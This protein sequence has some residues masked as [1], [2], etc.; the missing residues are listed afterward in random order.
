MDQFRD[1][2]GGW[3]WVA[4][5]ACFVGNVLNG[6]L[7]YSV[8]IFHVALLEEFQED[9]ATTAIV[10]SVYAGLYSLFGPFVS[11]VVNTTSC[12]TALMIGAVL[13]VLG[14]SSCF[15]ANSLSTVLFTY[16]IIAGL[17]S[18]FCATPILIM[19]GYSFKKYRGIANGVV[20]C[21]CG[22]GMLG[23]GPLSQYFIDTYGL[24][25]GFLMMGAVACHLIVCAALIRPSGAEGWHKKMRQ[26]SEDASKKCV[27]VRS[28]LDPSLY[29]NHAFLL[30]LIAGFGWN[31]AYAIVLLHLPNFSVVLGSSKAEA[32]MLLFVIGVGSSVS[33]VFG[34]LVTSN[35]AGIDPILLKLGVL[36]ITGVLTL[37]FP[38]YSHIYW[39]QVI[40]ACLFGIY[41]GGLIAFTVPIL[42]EIVGL[43]KLSAAVGAL[44]FMYG[45]GWFVGPTVAGLIIDHTGSYDIVFYV[46]GAIFTLAS[47]LTLLSTI[48]RPKDV[49]V[50]E[51]DRFVASVLF[52]D[53]NF[54]TG[55]MLLTGSTNVMLDFRASTMNMSHSSKSLGPYSSY[56]S[57]RMQSSNRSV[58]TQEKVPLKLSRLA[59]DNG[60]S[61]PLTVESV[62]EI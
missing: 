45:I 17:G 11:M 43:S 32:A 41:S 36:G 6:F 58:N 22:I 23:S 15:F 12:Q 7:N 61:A 19:T 10:G 4:M 62:S 25:G 1:V 14:F 60:E 29:K 13:T 49:N 53:S 3:A 8:G 57:V 28:I 27:Q 21:G 56:R 40:F 47:V 24:R 35:E 55:S 42:I 33:R 2:D 20:V 39:Q 31:V 54:L 48:W 38:F 52:K 44:Y 37:L 59:I 50:D 5:A 26:E 34:G 30:I 51:D 18:G 16:G 46:T 9:V